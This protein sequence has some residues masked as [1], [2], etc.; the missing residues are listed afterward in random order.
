MGLINPSPAL[1]RAIPF[2]IYI[3]FLVLES[4]LPSDAG[5][6][7]RWLYAVKITCVGIGLAWLWPG[8]AEL[9]RAPR[10]TGAAWVASVAVGIMIFAIWITLD[11]PW[12]VMGSVRGW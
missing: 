12:A 2:G 3:A 6:D 9:R 5:F 4:A 10:T 7:T 11:Q 8:Y 1:A